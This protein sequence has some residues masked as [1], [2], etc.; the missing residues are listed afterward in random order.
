MSLGN[1]IHTY[2]PDYDV[3]LKV[4]SWIAIIT[5][6]INFLN[7][8]LLSWTKVTEVNN[9]VRNNKNSPKERAEEVGGERTEELPCQD[10]HI[11]FLKM[12]LNFFFPVVP[13]IGH[14]LKRTPNFK[15]WSQIYPSPPRPP[16]HL[17]F[18][19]NT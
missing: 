15:P 12:F 4:Y 14:I 18:K 17:T 13:L 1:Y 10:P 8:P 9:E 3:D 19:I 2:I 11:F 7:F 6:V 5:S 16:P